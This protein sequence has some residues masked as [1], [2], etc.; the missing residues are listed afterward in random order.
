M[1]IIETGGVWKPTLTSAAASTLI[2]SIGRADAIVSQG[3]AGGTL[4][5][6]RLLE[7]VLF[8]GRGEN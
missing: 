1:H 7:F 8:V 4:H 2:R 5:Q 3:D 6:R